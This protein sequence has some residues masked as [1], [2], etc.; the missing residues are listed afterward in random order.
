MYSFYI[1]I[2]YNWEDQGAFWPSAKTILSLM[3]TFRQSIR[4]RKHQQFACKIIIVVIM[5]QADYFAGICLWYIGSYDVS[6]VIQYK[7]E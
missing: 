6:L 1:W 3:N 5:I 7:L 4:I 2:N